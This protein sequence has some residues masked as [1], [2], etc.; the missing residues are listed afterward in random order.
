MSSL[1]LLQG[2]PA[3]DPAIEIL[4]RADS[5]TG[6]ISNPCVTDAAPASLA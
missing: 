5:A 6:R 1:E 2:G 3:G 4:I